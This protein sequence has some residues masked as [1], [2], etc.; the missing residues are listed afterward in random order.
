LTDEKYHKSKIVTPE[1]DVDGFGNKGGFNMGK[2]FILSIV[3]T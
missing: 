2:D 1:E 3:S